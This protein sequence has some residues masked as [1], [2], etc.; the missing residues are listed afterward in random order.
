[1]AI[2]GEPAARGGQTGSL[3]HGRDAPLRPALGIVLALGAQ[4]VALERLR[5]FDQRQ[6]ASISEKEVYLEVE[7]RTGSQPDPHSSRE[8]GQGSPEP[9]R[10]AEVRQRCDT[11]Q[12]NVVT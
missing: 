12:V 2:A 8:S 5:G 11:Q 3:L 7:G 10:T 1:M 6:P 9:V 4:Q